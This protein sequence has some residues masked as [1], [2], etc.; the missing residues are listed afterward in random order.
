MYDRILFPTDGSDTAA[1]ALDYALSVAGHHGA[2]LHVLHVA[3]TTRDSVVQIDGQVVDA[4]EDEGE[5][6][7]QAAADRAASRGVAAVHEVLQ[8]DPY[9]T[10]VDYTEEFGMDLVVMATHGRRDVERFLLGSVTE[11]VLNTTT[12]PVMV[13]NPD[14][15]TDPTYPCRDV[16]VPTDGSEGAELALAAAADVA[17]ATGA[18]LHVLHVRETAGLGI[19]VRSALEREGADGQADELVEAAAGTARAAGVDAV[20]TAVREGRVYREILGYV[21]DHDVD[22]V[23][24]GTR[25]EAEFSRYVLGSVSAKIVRTSPV[26]LLMVREAAQQGS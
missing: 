23:T 1:A 9:R 15:Q 25:G 3:D 7:V 10:I 8:G 20:E 4:L 5:R 2:E 17:R 26:P 14:E 19:D 12:V 24:V 6:I 13:V 16:M 18:T 21:D 11:R 22:L